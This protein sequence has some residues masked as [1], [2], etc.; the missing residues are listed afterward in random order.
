MLSIFHIG[1]ALLRILNIKNILQFVYVCIEC[2]AL[3]ILEISRYVF[4]YTRNGCKGHSPNTTDKLAHLRD[5]F[6]FN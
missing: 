1:R 6:V 4:K 3:L 5:S 2:F